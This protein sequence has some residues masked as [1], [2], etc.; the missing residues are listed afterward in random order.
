MRGQTLPVGVKY[1]FI[2]NIRMTR[3]CLQ[4]FA[5]KRI[6]Y[7]YC[8]A[9]FGGSEER[10]V[11]IEGDNRDT[12]YDTSQRALRRP[13]ANCLAEGAFCLRRYGFVHVISFRRRLH[14]QQ[15]SKVGISKH[16]GTHHLRQ[17]PRIGL[18]G[19]S[20]FVS[21]QLPGDRRKDHG[22]QNSRRKTDDLQVSPPSGATL[23]SL[24]AYLGFHSPLFILFLS[25]LYQPLAFLGLSPYPA[26]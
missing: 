23:L 5:G 9:V 10:P 12:V 8:L 20:C 15:E 17:K 3:K 22:Y 21:L 13:F 14:G 11:R 25:L 1:D 7:F 24:Q 16:T 2:H 4:E 26:D 6:P 19:L 18:R